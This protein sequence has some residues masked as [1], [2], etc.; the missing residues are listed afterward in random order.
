[1]DNLKAFLL[2][3]TPPPATSKIKKESY[4]YDNENIDDILAG[5]KNDPEGSKPK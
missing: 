5:Y 2:E 3:E 1:M 4:G